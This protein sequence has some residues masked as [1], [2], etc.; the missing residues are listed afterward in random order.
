MIARSRRED[1]LQFGYRPNSMYARESREVS[2]DFSCRGIKHHDAVS[3]HVGDVQTASGRIE[4]LIVKTNRWPWQRNVG[5]R[6]QWWPVASIRFRLGGNIWAQ[7]QH[8]DG[9]LRGGY[10]VV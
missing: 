4:A 3:I 9:Q 1:A 2:Q 10:A 6:F 7:Q 8:R 5:D